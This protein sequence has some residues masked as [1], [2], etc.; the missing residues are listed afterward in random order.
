MQLKRAKIVFRN[1]IISVVVVLILFVLFETGMAMFVSM[2]PENMK[3]YLADHFLFP[4]INKLFFY[5]L[6]LSGKTLELGTYPQTED[7]ERLPIIWR[8][9]SNNRDGTFTLISDSVLDFCPYDVGVCFGYW[10]KCTL[11]VFL[12]EDFYHSSFSDWEKNIIVEN[13]TITKTRDSYWGIETDTSADK[14]FIPGI[15][16]VKLLKN[17][18]ICNPTDFARTKI[19]LLN[20]MPFYFD[21]NSEAAIWWIRTP[22]FGHYYATCVITQSGNIYDDKIYDPEGDFVP[23]DAEYVGV[24]PMIRIDYSKYIGKIISL[25]SQEK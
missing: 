10:S 18:L 7:G 11:R 1:I 14:I 24:R 25:K 21:A 3:P 20:H 19:Q 22:D 23:W 5:D 17:N 8:I 15:E 4:Y 2:A 13:C 9:V 12:N 16:D 6:P